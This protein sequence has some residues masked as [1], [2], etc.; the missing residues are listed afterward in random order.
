MLGCARR[1]PIEDGIRRLR[2]LAARMDPVQPGDWLESHREAGQ[3]YVQFRAAVRTRVVDAYRN[4]RIVPI[5]SLSAGHQ[6]VLDVTVDFMKPFFGLPLVMDP[7]VTLD[8]IP[9]EAQRQLFDSVT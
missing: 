7:P 4:I 5:G 1:D 3:T 2:R 9:A 8:S 6:A